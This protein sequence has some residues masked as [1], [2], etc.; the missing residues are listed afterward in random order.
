M[1]RTFYEKHR[2]YDQS[3]FVPNNYKK[4]CAQ[5]DQRQTEN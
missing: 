3:L 2:C 4:T 5:S 1:L